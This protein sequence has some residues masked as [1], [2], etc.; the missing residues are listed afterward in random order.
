M[1]NNNI[2]EMARSLG[3]L[4]K[5]SDEM[6]RMDKAEEAFNADGALSAM[7]EEYNAHQTALDS[8]DDQAFTEAIKKRMEEIYAAVSANPVYAEYYSAQ[9][10]VHNLMGR[11]NEEI[12]FV[13]T[14]EHSCGG[15]CEHCSGCH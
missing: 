14:G 15:G 13:V 1:D 3:Q 11:V 5:E 6:K 7:I 12:N 4:I 9:Q 10:G 2:M 8:T